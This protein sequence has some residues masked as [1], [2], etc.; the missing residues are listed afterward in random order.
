MAW[1]AAALALG[2][3]HGLASATSVPMPEEPIFSD[4]MSCT[5]DGATTFSASG[6][7]V[8]IKRLSATEGRVVMSLG[9][10]MTV[11]SNGQTHEIATGA[12]E[13][14]AEEG[15]YR[16][17]KAGSAG[18]WSSVYRIRDGEQRL[19][20]D[21]TGS[22]WWQLHGGAGPGQEPEPEPGPEPGPEPQASLMLDI[23]ELEILRMA[24]RPERTMRFNVGGTFRFNAARAGSVK[25]APPPAREHLIECAFKVYLEL[26]RA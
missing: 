19:V 7:Q 8:N 15:S 2:G 18:A 24:R 5:I 25:G 3:L 23:T 26:P 20:E 21:Y 9:L 10:G 6:A 11:A 17:P 12:F 14:P 1:A 16:F 4:K 13:L 22:A